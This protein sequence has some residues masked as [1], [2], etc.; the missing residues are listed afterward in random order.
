M[1]DARHGREVELQQQLQTELARVDPTVLSAIARAMERDGD[2]LVGG[3]WGVD[4]SDGCLLTLAARE[5]GLSRGE[6]LLGGS[7]AAVRIPALFDELWI[8]ILERTGDTRSARAIVHRLVIETL[9]LRADQAVVSETPAGSS[10][11]D[12]ER[13]ALT[14]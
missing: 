14:R 8:C 12:S 11:P 4:D 5:L 6:D 2:R 1:N 9:A 7:I 13:S 3:T 10:V